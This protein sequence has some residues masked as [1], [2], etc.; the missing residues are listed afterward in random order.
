MEEITNADRKSD[1]ELVEEYLN[2]IKQLI[3]YTKSKDDIIAQL[4]KDLQ[5]Y[6]DGFTAW[7]FKP[8]ILALI[9]F[10][11]SCKKD[12]NSLSRYT[13]DFEKVKK[14]INYLLE[15]LMELLF[16]NGV[17][18]KDGEFYYNGHNITLPLS[19]DTEKITNIT[20][21]SVFSTVEDEAAVALDCAEVQSFEELLE[22]Y[23]KEFVEILKD[24]SVLE[25]SYLML[26]KASA[27]VDV[28]NKMLLIFPVL[29]HLL[30][31]KGIIAS[32]F[33]ALPDADDLAKEC[34]GTILS[35][36]VTEIEKVLELMGCSVLVTDDVFNTT[37]HRLL[38][39]VDTDDQSLDRA[40][41][42]KLTDAYTLEGKVIFLQKVEVYKLKK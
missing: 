22:A 32:K 14:N 39:A 42:T 34:Y 23:H 27:K 29:K 2:K 37:Q 4:S 18:E 36:V 7:A 21:N 15:D 16:Q 17:E 25:E 13:F 31:L 26:L 1:F 8:F 6:R 35:C 24:N 41:C 5:H 19:F 10:R 20:K 9:D 3:R 30:E 12:I 33:Q 11:E 40:I 38:K 28:N